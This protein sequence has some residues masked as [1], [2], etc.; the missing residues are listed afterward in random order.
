VFVSVIS[1]D[2]RREVECQMSVV[3]AAELG[4]ATQSLFCCDENVALLSP[5][6]IE[7]EE[8]D[9]IT[10]TPPMSTPDLDRRDTSAPPDKAKKESSG[11]FCY[12]LL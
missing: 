6:P 3:W 9:L 7:L 8:A 4:T 1:D 2:V 5:G 10:M 11:L 12:Y